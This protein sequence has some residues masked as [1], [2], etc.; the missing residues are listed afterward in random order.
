MLALDKRTNIISKYGTNFLSAFA[1]TNEM[2]VDRIEILS[3]CIS[4][5]MS[6]TD[7]KSVPYLDT[8]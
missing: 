4:F 7:K 8:I 5:V 3:T 6:N 1:I 2:Q